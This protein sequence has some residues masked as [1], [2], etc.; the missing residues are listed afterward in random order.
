MMESH[1]TVVHNC[2][3]HCCCFAVAAVWWC[4]SVRVILLTRHQTR[5]GYAESKQ[6][7]LLNLHNLLGELDTKSEAH[8]HTQTHTHTPCGAKI[9]F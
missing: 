5:N 8:T 3:W 6:K 2:H 7:K 9:E 4:V 1:D